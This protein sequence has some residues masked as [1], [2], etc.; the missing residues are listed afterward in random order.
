[1]TL[2]DSANQLDE[3]TIHFIVVSLEQQNGENDGIL[4]EL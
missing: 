2:L 1:M 3:L 4:N